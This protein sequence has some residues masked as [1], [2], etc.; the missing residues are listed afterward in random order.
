MAKVGSKLKL[1]F[2]PDGSIKINAQKMIGTETELLKDLNEL[3]SEAGGELKVEKH[4]HK[5]DHS[6]THDDHDHENA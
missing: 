4:V 2:N 5:H 3:A 6:H 1:T